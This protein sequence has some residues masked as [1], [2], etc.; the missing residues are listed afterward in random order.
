MRAAAHQSGAP[1]ALDRLADPQPGQFLPV[2]TLL[3]ASLNLLGV[4]IVNGQ[5]PFRRLQPSAPLAGWR[6]CSSVT[7]RAATWPARPPRTARW[8]TWCRSRTGRLSGPAGLAPGLAAAEGPGT[9]R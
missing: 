6:S 5:F 7:E 3:M 4:A 8:P 9:S 2:G 1:S